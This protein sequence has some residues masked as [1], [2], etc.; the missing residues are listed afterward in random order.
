M[1]VKAMKSGAEE[2]LPKPFRDQDLIDAIQQALKRDNETRQQ[3]NEI[4]ELKAR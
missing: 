4:A 1:C 3:Q 2:F